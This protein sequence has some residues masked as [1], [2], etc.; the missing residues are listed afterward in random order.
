[1][2][3]NYLYIHKMAKVHEDAKRIILSKKGLV[4]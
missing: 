4:K 1:M 2:A 3:N